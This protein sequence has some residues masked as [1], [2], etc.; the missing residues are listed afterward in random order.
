MPKTE[1][2]GFVLDDTAD[3]LT[4]EQFANFKRLM[5][6]GKEAKADEYLDAI[7]ASW[8]LPEGERPV[9]PVPE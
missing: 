2:G 4:E 7:M 6:S 3:T 5:E 1:D 9:I 8:E